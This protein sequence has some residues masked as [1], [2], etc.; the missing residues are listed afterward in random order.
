MQLRLCFSSQCVLWGQSFT[1]SGDPVFYKPT[2]SAY[3]LIIVCQCSF[4][5]E[6]KN[7]KFKQNS[8]FGGV[9]TFNAI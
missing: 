7:K 8:I 1:V 9:L 6:M 5:S 4:I 3:Q 2:G